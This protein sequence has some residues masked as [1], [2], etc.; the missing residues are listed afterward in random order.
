VKRHH[1]FFLLLT[2][3]GA[4]TFGTN[5]F[6][7]GLDFEAQTGTLSY[8]SNDVSDTS[9]VNT[10]EVGPS[11]TAGF[12]TWVKIT[13]DW[14]NTGPVYWTQGVYDHCFVEGSFVACPATNVWVRTLKGDDTISVKP[15]ITVP[16]LLEGGGGSDTITG[17]GE[18]DEIWGACK[19]DLANQCYGF[20]DTLNGGGGDDTLIGG[21]STPV[22]G[23]AA[24]VLHGG[25]GDD[26]L[27]GGQGADQLWGDAGKDTAWYA[28][29][30][31]P[32]TASLDNAANDGEAGEN[33]Y[34]HTDIEAIQGGLGKDTLNGGNTDDTLKGGPG[35]DTLNGYGGADYLYGEEGSDL[36]RPGP[37]QDHLYGGG[38]PANSCCTFDTATYSERWNPVNLSI[39]GNANDGEAGEGDYIDDDIEGLAG[40]SNND[41]LIGSTRGNI[42]T[43]NA[44]QDTLLGL[45]SP[46]EQNPGAGPHFP[47]SLNGGP[48][49]D[50][51]NGG[52]LGSVGDKIDG[53]AGTDTLTYASRSD[54]VKVYLDG[55]DGSED[56]IDNIDNVITGSGNDTIL[57]SIGPNVIYAG[58]GNDAVDGGPSSDVIHG[59]DDNDWLGGGSAGDVILGEDG[60]DT[61]QGGLGADTISGNTGV[62]KVTYESEILPVSVSLGDVAN[63]GLA[64]EGDN[65]G[66]DIENITGGAGKDT[67]TGSNSANSILGGAGNDTIFGQG[68]SDTL[69]G[70]PN[71]DTIHGGT[72]GDTLDGGPD[73]DTLFGDD[74]VDTLAGGPGSDKLYGGTGADWVDYKDAA[75]PV[76]VNLAKGKGKSKTDG[77]D[78]LKEIEN[79]FGS[80]F[81][82]TLTG[83]AMAN[84]L[85]GF[86]GNDTIDGGGGLDHLFGAVGDDS[87]RGGLGDDEVSGGPGTDTADFA[88]APAGEIIDLSTYAAS[89]NGGDGFDWLSLIENVTGS[90]KP[91]TITGSADANIF[92]G[93]GGND[94]LFG[95]G[96]DDTLSGDA[97]LDTVDGGTNTDACVA[98]TK[99][100]CEL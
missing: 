41:T 23:K 42:L 93:G 26:K 98:E 82:D 25:P 2:I 71:N 11:E 22:F 91:D 88:K 15:G 53:G 70:G 58:A 61:L 14:W 32:I 52:P 7:G 97:G 54:D 1:L 16:V 46:Q 65:V 17:G 3:I 96:G 80:A 78:K 36:L 84:T 48:D 19:V 86:E 90:A 24:D 38:D 89:A 56:D 85:S 73:K 99:A 40:G 47:D 66:S 4:L 13:Y 35:D 45:G 55:T 5:A 81:D 77:S 39:D 94:S 60:A 63:D 34:I 10:I 44:G 59:G 6:A 20:S 92:K 21:D 43:G 75:G 27:E 72:E 50:S 87:I 64:G 79:A 37:G 8:Y 74:G 31:N 83:D 30:G 33:D 62:D 95:L 100:N 29:R 18:H 69:D 76:S 51:L 67:L 28:P 57:G 9:L 49:D 12:H 68:G